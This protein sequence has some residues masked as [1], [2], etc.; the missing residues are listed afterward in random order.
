MSDLMDLHIHLA[1]P[2]L[3][4]EESIFLAGGEAPLT[5]DAASIGHQ[6]TSAGGPSSGDVVS[7]RQKLTL[8]VGILPT[9][10]GSVLVEPKDPCRTT[11]K[12]DR[13]L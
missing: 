10:V 4:M 12:T 11:A 9:T 2:D 1:N 8:A 7:V 3:T 5:R 6:A 13:I